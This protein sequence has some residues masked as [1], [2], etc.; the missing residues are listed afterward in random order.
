MLHGIRCHETKFAC[1]NRRCRVNTNSPKS[2]AKHEGDV[3]F[4]CLLMDQQKRWCRQKAEAH[5]D[6]IAW[7]GLSE[8]T[9]HDQRRSNAGQLRCQRARRARQRHTEPIEVFRRQHQRGPCA[10]L[11]ADIFTPP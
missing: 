1:E 7:S 9:P 6:P 10:L 5:I 4:N 3:T 11:L 2:G 8:C